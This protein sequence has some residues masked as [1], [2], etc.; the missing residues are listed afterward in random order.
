LSFK[1]LGLNDQLLRAL[2]ACGFENPTEIQSKAIPLALQG[3]DVMGS[4]QTGTGKTAA[5][6]LPMLHRLLTNPAKPGHGPR[7]LVLAPTRELATQVMEVVRDMG[8]FARIRQATIVGGVPYGPQFRALR[9]PLDV[10]VAT[11]GRLI[12]HIERGSVDFSRVEVLVLDEADRMLDMGFQKAVE[13]IASEAPKD[14]QTMLF[15]AT[16]EGGVHDVARRHLNNPQKVELT[17]STKR[18][19]QITQWAHMSHGARHK[20][21]MLEHLLIDANIDKAVVFTA[22]KHRAKTLAADLAEM[23]HSSAA[24]HGNMTQAARLRTVEQL[25]RGKVKILVATDVAARGLDV[26]GISHVI[27]YEMPMTPEDYIHRIGRTGRAGASGTAITLVSGPERTMMNSIERLTGRRLEQ[28]NLD[29]VKPIDGDRHDP[30]PGRG[31]RGGGGGGRSRN[32]WSGGAG[33]GGGNRSGAGNGNGAAGGKS[34]GRSSDWKATGTGNGAG[35]AK[36][37]SAPGRRFE[38][39]PG[40]S[41]EGRG[42]PGGGSRPFGRKPGNNGGAKPNTRRSW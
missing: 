3:G 19:E 36:K 41:D 39:G 40:R 23:G 34:W 25:K 7:G 30:L 15:S 1:E 24:L 6:V 29:A 20:Q 22:T 27:N 10:L 8:K 42:G 37:F 11:P 28:R 12:D 33:A 17:A 26:Q 16:L 32:A 13:R 4:A 31:G 2:E 14:R 5:F 18:H 35:G 21:A 38:G 9:A